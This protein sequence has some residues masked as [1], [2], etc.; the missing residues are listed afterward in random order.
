[1]GVASNKYQAATEKLVAHYFPQIN[2]IKV[3]GQRDGIPAKPSPEIVDE[4]VEIAGVEKSDVLYVGDAGVDMETALNGGVTACG[5]TWG[6]R[7]RTDLEQFH[8]KYI[9][10]TVDELRSILL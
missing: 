4:L 2:F 9:V 3:L 10:N 7:P 1:M 6:F 8:P 5:V